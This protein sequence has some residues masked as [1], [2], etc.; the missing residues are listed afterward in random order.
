MEERLPGDSGSY[1]KSV[2]ERWCVKKDE[3]EHIKT[4][5]NLKGNN[6]VLNS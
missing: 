3:D 1:L 5:T 4:K 6:F 2:K